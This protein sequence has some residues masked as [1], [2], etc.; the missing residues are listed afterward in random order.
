MPENFN[1]AHNQS[2]RYTLTGLV[3]RGSIL[4][5]LYVAIFRCSIEPDHAVC[6][7][8]DSVLGHLEP[9][10]REKVHPHIEP[11][12][13]Q[14]TEIYGEHGAPWVAKGFEAYNTHAY[15]H[16]QKANEAIWQQYSTHAKPHVDKYTHVANDLYD[17][18][19]K[20]VI[21]TA[22]EEY[23]LPAYQK[24]QPYVQNAYEKGVPLAQR[25]SEQSYEAYVHHVS[26]AVQT[27]WKKILLFLQT[28]VVP[29][30]KSVHQQYVKPQINKIMDKVFENEVTKAKKKAKAQE[31][32]AE[33]ITT[34]AESTPE[35]ETFTAEKVSEATSD[36]TPE[37]VETPEEEVTPEVV[38]EA[39]AEPVS[40]PAPEPPVEAEPDV[41]TVIATSA[42]TSM[43][44]P[45]PAATPS[46]G[47]NALDELIG[48]DDDDAVT[49]SAPT[50]DANI[51]DVEDAEEEHDHHHGHSH[52]THSVRADVEAKQVAF[53]SEI[54]E[55]ISSERAKFL[56]HIKE[57]R[58]EAFDTH[59]TDLDTR[60]G[61]FKTRAMKI[62][63]QVEKLTAKLAKNQDLSKEDKTTDLRLGVRRAAEKVKAEARGILDALPAIRH[64]VQT[65]L[66]TAATAVTEDIE[67]LCF[68]SQAKMG[69]LY[70]NMPDVTVEDWKK[71]HRFADLAKEAMARFLSLA[72]GQI[73]PIGQVHSEEGVFLQAYQVDKQRFEQMLTEV[74]E[75]INA[76]VGEIGRTLKQRRE[77]GLEMIKTGQEIKQVTLADVEDDHGSGC[78]DHLHSKK[79]E[80]DQKRGSK[81]EPV[82]HMPPG[83]VVSEGTEEA[84]SGAASVAAK[85]ESMVKGAAASA[86]SV[87]AK[88]TEGA[89]SV[90]SKVSVGV[91]SK[92]SVVSD[93]A[94][95]VISKGTKSASEQASTVASSASSYRDEAAESRSAAKAYAEGL[96]SRMSSRAAAASSS[97][98]QAAPI[99]REPKE[100]NEPIKILPIE[101]LG[102]HQRD[103]L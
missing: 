15:P 55:K 88:G 99:P 19:A 74:E 13:N 46:S 45:Q 87:V 41:E 56:T 63:K 57:I 17:T 96:A 32:N 101:D 77:S 103:E 33:T 68:S 12:L 4:Y 2:S 31:E 27:A 59:S 28:E 81:L 21:N 34:E 62:I 90:M 75:D 79:H 83:A 84:K 85:A 58:Q 89:A 95:S 54:N 39:E 9:H 26:P 24:T 16:V 35:V 51:E 66:V 48:D 29:R 8:R 91:S 92:A 11:Y 82:R 37:M 102:Q 72:Q 40:P 86:S 76:L 93:S 65:S 6:A 60:I 100:G 44:T 3:L 5:T 43:A 50:E 1:I 67:A 80:N 18:H 78:R 42:A 70:E 73:P 10:Y 97:V 64:D 22:Y 61:D 36:P 49:G 20:P 25:A 47:D 94:S 98:K 38:P 52:N 71:Y 23:A 69:E 7:L 14:A 53:E 30:V